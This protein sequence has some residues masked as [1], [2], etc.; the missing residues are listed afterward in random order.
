[1]NTKFDELAKT[2]RELRQLVLDHAQIRAAQD[3]AT[4]SVRKAYRLV[5]DDIETDILVA[6]KNFDKIW[7]SI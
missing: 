3:Q 1:M 7:D 2:K 5:L 4:K 6:Q